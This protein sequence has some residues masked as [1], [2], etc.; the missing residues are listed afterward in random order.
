MLTRS[1]IKGLRA[2]PPRE[3]E[4]MKAKLET[5]AVSPFANHL[6]A[7]AFGDGVTRI[8]HGDWRAVCEIDQGRIIVLVLKIGNRREIYR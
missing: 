2:M 5:F 1:A 3:A 4:A 8:R 6:W 7:K